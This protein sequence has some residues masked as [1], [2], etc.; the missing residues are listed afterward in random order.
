MTNLNTMT[1]LNKKTQDLNKM[2]MDLNIMT[3]DL[4]IRLIS[5]PLR[6]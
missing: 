2:T 5:P 4:N 6:Y 1:S 3:N